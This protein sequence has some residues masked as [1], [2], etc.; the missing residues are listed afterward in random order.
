MLERVKKKEKTHKRESATKQA[1]ERETQF[2]ETGSETGRDTAKSARK[3]EPKSGTTKTVG[4]SCWVQS[5]SSESVSIKS[6]PSK[7]FRIISTHFE[8][9]KS[10][11]SFRIQT[12]PSES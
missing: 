7:P 3:I 6:N 5:K 9:I 10:I 4:C 2:W 12:N 11:E 1:Q 8:S